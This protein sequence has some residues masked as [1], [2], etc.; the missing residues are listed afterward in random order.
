M[1]ARRKITIDERR[2]RL[3]ERHRLT[4]A[5]KTDDIAAIADSVV[6]L[7]SSD[8]ATVYLSALARMQHPEIEEQQQ[9]DQRKETEPKPDHRREPR[10]CRVGRGL[11][12]FNRGV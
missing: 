3:A 7:H 9:R 11:A 2:A 12:T 5:T 10:P 8:P 1:T 4:T 6:A